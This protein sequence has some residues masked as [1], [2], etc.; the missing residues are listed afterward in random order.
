MLTPRAPTISW[1][2]APARISIPRRVWLISSH[3]P[4]ATSRP[5]PMNSRRLTGYIRPGS[6]STKALY[7]SGVG[8]AGGLR[9]NS[10]VMSSLVK[11]TTARVASTWS[12]WSRL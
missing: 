10:R 3:I 11:N 9:P 6:T 4:R 8:M 1:S 2:S 12:R 5:A 7:Q